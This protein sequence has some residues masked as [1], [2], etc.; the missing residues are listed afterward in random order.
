[1]ADVEGVFDGVGEVRGRSG[2]FPAEGGVAGLG[3][4]DGDGSGAGGTG[5]DG[6]RDVDRGGLGGT[7]EVVENEDVVV[8]DEFEIDGGVGGGGV[9]EDGFED[10]LIA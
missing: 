1:M 4:A 10:D 8:G 7:A 2:G 5:W 6:D 9:V 3:E